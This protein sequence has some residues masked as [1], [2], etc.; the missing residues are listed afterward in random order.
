MYLDSEFQLQALCLKMGT[1]AC[2]IFELAAEVCCFLKSKAT[3]DFEKYL[4]G[5]SLPRYVTMYVK[6][7]ITNDDI[8]LWDALIGRSMWGYAQTWK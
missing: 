3:S 6:K 5:D 7:N 4:L 1:S 2:R 8:I